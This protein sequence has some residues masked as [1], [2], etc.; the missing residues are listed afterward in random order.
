VFGASYD[1]GKT[2]DRHVVRYEFP[3]PRGFG[4]F[5]TPQLAA[6]PSRPGRFAIMALTEDNS[7]MQVF[8]TEDYGKTWKGPVRAGSTPGATILKPDMNYSPR[9]ELAVMWLAV[10]PDRTYSCWSAVSHDGG[11]QFSPSLQVSRGPSPPR[12]SIKNRGNNWDGD[13]L[14]TI[15]VDNDYVHIVWAD[16]RAGFLGDWYARVPLAGY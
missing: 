12:Q 15:A 6:D 11:R 10:Y 2:F 7:E 16:G 14:S 3:A 9:G 8:L 13:D 4:G 5:G 1:E